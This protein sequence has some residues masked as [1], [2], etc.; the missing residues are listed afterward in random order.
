V[1]WVAGRESGRVLGRPP[2]R[3]GLR[4]NTRSPA[5][6]YSHMPVPIT[7]PSSIHGHG[8]HGELDGTEG[9]QFQ[10]IDAEHISRVNDGPRQHQACTAGD[11]D[12]G[13]FQHTVG[14][15]DG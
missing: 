5:S 12:R 7:H 2:L 1:V 4:V 3:P 11:E 6:K 9:G 15:D 8:A 14:S 10:R 13:Q